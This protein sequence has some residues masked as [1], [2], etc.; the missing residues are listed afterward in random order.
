MIM[1]GIFCLAAFAQINAQ[2]LTVREK[3]SDRQGGVIPGVN[4]MKLDATDIENKAQLIH[5][6]FDSSKRIIRLQDNELIEDDAP[7]TGLPEGYK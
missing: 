7:A 1:T 2:Q 4:E 6:V 5:L 3:V